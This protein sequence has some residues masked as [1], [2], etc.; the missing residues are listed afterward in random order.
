MRQT[1]VRQ[2][3]E[4]R[5]LHESGIPAMVEILSAIPIRLAESQ[6]LELHLRLTAPGLVPFEATVQC[7]T[8]PDLRPGSRLMAK[9]DPADQLFM[10]IR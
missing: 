5:H 10:I 7:A 8:E 9:V 1:V 4:V 3:R 6:G 2:A